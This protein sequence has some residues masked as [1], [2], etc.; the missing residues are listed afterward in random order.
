M[1]LHS[2]TCGSPP[3]TSFASDSEATTMQTRLG[4]YRKINMKNIKM[5]IIN[6]RNNANFSGKG[7]VYK[8]LKRSN[9]F[10][11]HWLE[12]HL[13]PQAI[14]QSQRTICP[15]LVSLWVPSAITVLYQES[16]VRCLLRQNKE[17]LRHYVSRNYKY[18]RWSFKEQ[19]KPTEIGKNISET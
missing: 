18:I 5:M 9:Y 17:T 2:V 13:A 7:F 1:S 19:K 6:K 4:V 12:I 8:N 3:M 16:F 11:L 10:L 14:S 15:F